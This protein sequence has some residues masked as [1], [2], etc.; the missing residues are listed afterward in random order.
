MLTDAVQLTV[1]LAEP[2]GRPAAAERLARYVGADAL[3]ILV[4]DPAVEALVPA[5]GFPATLPGGHGWRSLLAAAR[6]PGLHRGTVAFPS[7]AA[8]APALAYAHSGI[9][10]VFVGATADPGR[11]ESLAG[12]VPLLAA[13]LRAERETAA[14][15]GEKRVALDYAREAKALAA[16]L[17]AARS[18]LEQTLR[19]LEERSRSL[20]EARTR[21]ERAVRA[22]DEFLAMLGHELRNPLSPILTAVQLLR[23]NGRV[24]SEHEIIERQVTNLIR[25]VEDLLDV[26][27]LTTGK[28][29]LRKER[30]EI[31]DVA[32]RAI[33]MVSPMLESKQQVLSVDIPSHGLVVDGDPTRLA[34]VLANLLTN[35]AKYSDDGT[36]I[37][38]EAALRGS[39]IRIRVRDEGIGIPPEMLIR[40]FDLFEQQRQSIDRS[41]GGL[42]LGLAIVR[43][44]VALHGGTVRAESEGEGKGAEFIVELPRAISAPDPVQ[45]P[46]APGRVNVEGAGTRLLVVDDNPDVLTLMT[47]ALTDVGYVVETAADGLAALKTAER[48]LPEVAIL[49]IGLP[50]MDGYELAARLRAGD[51]TGALRLIAVTGYGQEADRR[52]ARK[53]GFHAHLVKPVSLDELQRV[54]AEVRTPSGKG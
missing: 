7:A 17:D 10:L 35:A 38:V 28:I 39:Q 36:H 21:A 23:L 5:P 8:S 50:V 12:V 34:Q 52:R 42:G 19:A 31:S 41:Q 14:A 40:V 1:A 26:S 49:D 13:A 16:A 51:S 44:L 46:V 25:L 53:A 32:A 48:F 27:R 20:D 30:I 9:V 33:E 54:V 3:T 47:Y 24:S 6:S 2:G 37:S 15:R 29:V 11:I 4:E 43:S 18:E 22:K 45:Q